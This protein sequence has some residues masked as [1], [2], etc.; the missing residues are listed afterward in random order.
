MTRSRRPLR[1]YLTAMALLCTFGSSVLWWATY[2]GQVQSR[3]LLLGI[4]VVWAVLC[5]ALA[6]R[7]SRPRPVRRRAHARKGAR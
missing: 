4:A 1:G 3:P 6:H 5:D 2:T 7:V